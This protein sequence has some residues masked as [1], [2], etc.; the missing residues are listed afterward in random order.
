MQMYER[1]GDPP[2][3]VIEFKVAVIGDAQRLAGGGNIRAGDPDGE[4]LPLAVIVRAVVKLFARQTG[5]VAFLEQ[6]KISS[7]S[8]VGDLPFRFCQRS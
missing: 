5:H 4:H 7:G 3:H 8:G 6:I 1:A 2:L